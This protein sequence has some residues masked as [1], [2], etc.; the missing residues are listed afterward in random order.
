LG[1][2]K[3][4]ITTEEKMSIESNS[5]RNN[6]KRIMFLGFL[7]LLT[8]TAVSLLHAN[9]PEFILARFSGLTE[10]EYS[11]F[12]SVVYIAY[13]IMGI[14]TYIISD[15]I[16]KRKLFIII[17]SI[18]SSVFFILMTTT[19]I[20]PIL[21]IYRFLQGSFTVMSWQILMTLV[22]DYSESNDRGRN[23][24]IF[25]VFL[26]L[27][28]GLGPMI[29]GIIASIDVFMPYWVAAFLSLLVLP[30]TLF[31]L[32]DPV[33]IK[34]R[35]SLKQSIMSAKEYPKLV[36]PCLFNFID[37][38]HMGFILTAL[39]LFLFQ[40]LGLSES[41]RGMALGLFAIPFIILQYPMGKISDKY[42]RYKQ[43]VIG[44]A[45]YGIILSI[46]GFAGSFGF[47]H[48]VIILILLGVFSGITSPASMALIGDSVGQD[49]SAMAMGFF[50]FVGNMGIVIGPIVLGLLLIYSNFAIAF[51]VAGLIE[52]ISLAIIIVIIKGKFKE[53]IF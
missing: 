24:G 37:R 42:G 53:N 9:E 39:P 6:T 41:L 30:L 5:S 46:L 11:Y 43:L 50:N 38:L 16:G 17:G 29:G 27:A 25:G 52:L 19:T 1:G 4:L 28:M 34:K 44:S 45:I 31:G 3:L 7:T 2:S 23:M 14:S 40:V 10:L 18:G 20:Y 15:K 21:L 47:I 49:E 51:L 12:D 26:A 22:L 36:V 48:L 8:I 32:D 13:L 35:V 33:F